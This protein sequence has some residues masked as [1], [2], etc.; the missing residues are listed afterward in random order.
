MLT[1][2][3]HVSWPVGSLRES[4]P[5]EVSS[6]FDPSAM[7]LTPF[8]GQATVS[9]PILLNQT[10]RRN[11]VGFVSRGRNPKAKF[12]DGKSHEVGAETEAKVVPK[13][14]L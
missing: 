10:E 13:L 11:R 4:C 8:A 1:P 2:A 9:L 7:E 6:A 14:M 12:A 3:F 5:L